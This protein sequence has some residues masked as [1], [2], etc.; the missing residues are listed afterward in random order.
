MALPEILTVEDLFDS[1]VRAGAT[2]L[3]GRHQ[4]RLPGTVEAPSEHLGAECRFGRRRAVCDRRFRPQRIQLPT[5]R[6]VAGTRD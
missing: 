6:L 3:A 5:T 2:I 4:D 1:P